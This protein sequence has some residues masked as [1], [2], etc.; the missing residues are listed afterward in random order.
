VSFPRTQRRATASRVSG[1]A[2][3][4]YALGQ[5]IFLR[6]PTAKLTE[7]ELKNSLKSA[8]EAKAEQ[9]L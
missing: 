2:R 3:I 1:L 7:L 8:E 9:L 6:P 5:E 4:P